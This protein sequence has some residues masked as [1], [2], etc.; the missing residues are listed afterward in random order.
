[1]PEVGFISFCR[2]LFET[3]GLLEVRPDGA[4]FIEALS[5]IKISNCQDGT[6]RVNIF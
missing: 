1:M 5:V 6:W 3:P 4:P 2:S